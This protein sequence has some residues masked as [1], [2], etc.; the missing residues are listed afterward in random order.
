MVAT[1]TII[2]EASQYRSDFIRGAAQ[3]LRRK[4]DLRDSLG[5]PI[6][7]ADFSDFLIRCPRSVRSSTL[8]QKPN[9]PYFASQS[10]PGP[11]R[12]LE[13]V[14]E[15]AWWSKYLALNM[16]QLCLTAL[17]VTAIGSI[18]GLILSIE[19]VYTAATP[20]TATTTLTLPPVGRLVTAI[21]MLVV[22]LGV[23]RLALGYFNF[24]RKAHTV[25]ETADRILHGTD[26]STE[27]ALKV[28]QEYHLARAAAP[29]LPNWLWK[30]R[31]DALNATWKRWRQNEQHL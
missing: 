26:C 2:S 1:L 25:E 17:I 3:T 19:T 23:I 14:R 5:W 20:T 6:S 8:N 13:N 30:L 10:H 9:E 12:A 11:K 28:I 16:F 15:S 24:Y 29:S 4:L 21:L 22:S 27:D 18:V 7:G 31:R